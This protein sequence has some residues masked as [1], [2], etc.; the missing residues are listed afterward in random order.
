MRELSLCMIHFIHSVYLCRP[1]KCSLLVHLAFLSIFIFPLST[2]SSLSIYPSQ[3]NSCRTVG[4]VHVAQV[5]TPVRRTEKTAVTDAF[6]TANLVRIFISPIAAHRRDDLR[7]ETGSIARKVL[8]FKMTFVCVCMLGFNMEVV[9]EC[10]S[11]SDVK[12]RCQD[13]FSCTERDKYTGHCKRCDPIT[14]PTPSRGYT[15]RVYTSWVYTSTANTLSPRTQK[16]SNWAG[17]C[18]CF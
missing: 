1:N 10:K 9:E 7:I 17:K 16:T 5:S 6:R 15:S 11:T 18:C 12:C 2:F 4:A 14:T 13:G 3:D 8:R